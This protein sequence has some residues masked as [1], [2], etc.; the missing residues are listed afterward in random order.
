M[1]SLIVP[2][3]NP[4]QPNEA[5]CVTN[6]ILGK[7]SQQPD[8]LVVI[9]SDSHVWW[10]FES[11]QASRLLSE[12]EESSLL[13]PSHL[14]SPHGLSASHCGTVFTAQMGDRNTPIEAVMEI[15]RCCWQQIWVSSQYSFRDSR[16]IY[17]MW[18]DHVDAVIQPVTWI[19]LAS[20][21]DFGWVDHEG[22]MNAETQDIPLTCV[23][24]LQLLLE[25]YWSSFI[26]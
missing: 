23:Q 20:L 14:F 15:L 18:S 4:L 2:S 25:H 12:V 9:N 7:L 21:A 24:W 13:T 10:Y 1:F 16:N 3:W 6:C 22:N 17:V 8:Q 5:R 19:K 26:R 11:A